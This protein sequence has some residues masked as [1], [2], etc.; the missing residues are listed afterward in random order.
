M[1]NKIPV[2]CCSA[3]QIN[4]NK[5]CASCGTEKKYEDCNYKIGDIIYYIDD[6]FYDRGLF[7]LSLPYSVKNTEI[8]NIRNFKAEMKNHLIMSLNN[9]ITSQKEAQKLCDE[10]NLRELKENWSDIEKQYNKLK[11]FYNKQND[12]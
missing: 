8:I 7:D 5:F 2:L 10:Y 6:D 11:E 3:Y 12:K 1:N 4:N 9:I